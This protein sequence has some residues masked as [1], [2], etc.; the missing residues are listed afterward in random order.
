VQAR[1]DVITVGREDGLVE[2]A[3]RKVELYGEMVN[4]SVESKRLDPEDFWS[5]VGDAADPMAP[6]GEVA[7]M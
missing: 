7:G 5:C 1:Q 4:V 6:L 2:N 3:V